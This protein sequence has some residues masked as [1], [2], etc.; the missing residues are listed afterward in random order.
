MRCPD[1]LKKVIRRR[2]VHF[3]HEFICYG[4]FRTFDPSIKEDRE[5]LEL[6]DNLYSSSA[7][8]SPVQKFYAIKSWYE[9]R[10]NHLLEVMIQTD[11]DGWVVQFGMEGW[12]LWLAD[13]RRDTLSEAWDAAV[14]ILKSEETSGCDT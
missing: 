12:A 3:D 13:C 2:G 6:G 14:E 1:C 10:N 11:M 4:C 7:R 5:E 8:D 9:A